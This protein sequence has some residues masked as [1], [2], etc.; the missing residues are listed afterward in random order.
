[1]IQSLQILLKQTELMKN[2]GET[3]LNRSELR[4]KINQFE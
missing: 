3:S 4:H 2:D 1:M